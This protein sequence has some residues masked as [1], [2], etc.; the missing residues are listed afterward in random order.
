MTDTTTSAP[1][2]VRDLLVKC[3]SLLESNV[4]LKAR[5]MHAEQ[6]MI[7]DIRNIVRT[8]AA[9]P[10]QPAGDGFD[11][12]FLAGV[13][14]V[15]DLAEQFREEAGGS[16]SY[17]QACR[18]IVEA[19]ERVTTTALNADAGAWQPIETAPK[20]GS[21]ALLLTDRNGEPYACAAFWSDSADDPEDHG[22]YSS[23]CASHKATD[24]G[25]E[26]V[27]WMPLPDPPRLKPLPL[28]HEPFQV[29]RGCIPGLPEWVE[30]IPVFTGEPLVRVL[31]ESHPKDWW[32]YRGGDE[33]PRLYGHWGDY[34]VPIWG[35]IEV[36][37]PEQVA[38][39]L[40]GDP[41]E[42]CA[43]VVEDTVVLDNLCFAMIEPPA[44]DFAVQAAKN[45]RALGEKERA[46]LSEG[47]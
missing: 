11:R 25:D 1:D 5:V 13:R 16:E 45:I 2:D 6:R 28:D 44:G 29:T 20:D 34:L 30:A 9:K 38:E 22:W 8:L 42:E 4:R 15:A 33:K 35:R 47:R 40:G 41:Y 43:R 39:R 3:Q 26:F 14:H 24:F 27:Q 12:G 19:A 31:G 17:R 7:V 32:I 18:H 23:E 46:K 10:E 21:W 37:T 36:W